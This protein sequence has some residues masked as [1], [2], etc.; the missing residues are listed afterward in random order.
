VDPTPLTPASKIAAEV[1]KL[2]EEAGAQEEV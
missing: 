2:E 1:A